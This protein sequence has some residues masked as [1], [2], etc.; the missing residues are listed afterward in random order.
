MPNDRQ[1]G[2][3]VWA[4][5]GDTKPEALGQG[6]QLLH[7]VVFVDVVAVPVGKALLHKMTAVAGGVNDHVCGFRC[8]R[9]LQ[10]G[11][12]RTE[13]VVIPNKGKIVDEENEFQGIEGERV[14]DRRERVK[15]LLAQFQDTKSLP[16]QSLQTA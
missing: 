6:Y 7:G 11:F 2:G 14:Q 9:A 16:E 10:K 5:E 1:I 13:I 15:L 4:G 12:Q 3:F 8:H